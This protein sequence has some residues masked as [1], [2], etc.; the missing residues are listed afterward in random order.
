MK[1]HNIGR[2]IALVA[3][4]G[5]LLPALA[6]AQEVKMGFVDSRRAI[7]SSK[8]GKAV[9]D[10]LTRL[11]S[12]KREEF[13]PREEK[14]KKLREEFDAQRFVL[15]QEA[16]QEKQLELQKMRNDIERDMAAAE[17]E[18][19]IEQRKLMDPLLRKALKAV[20]EVGKEKNFTVIL[21]RASPGV[22]YYEEALDVTDLV[23][24]RP[25][26]SE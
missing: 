3:A 10:R 21:E 8:S 15:S 12:E 9:E 1:V 19:E 16:L 23:I 6:R 5:I 24:Q 20:G 26:E 25:N 7:F 14:L 2:L 22:L 4:V 18:L 17:E 13:R 11:M